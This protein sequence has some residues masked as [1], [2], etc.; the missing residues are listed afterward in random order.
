MFLIIACDMFIAVCRMSSN[1]ASYCIYTLI[2]TPLVLD[3][4]R[5]L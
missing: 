5:K 1:M 4:L 3:R 2:C